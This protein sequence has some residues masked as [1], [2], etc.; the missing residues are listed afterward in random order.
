MN[1]SGF[2]WNTFE[3]IVARWLSV[4]ESWGLVEEV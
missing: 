4:F 3:D 2:S 1:P